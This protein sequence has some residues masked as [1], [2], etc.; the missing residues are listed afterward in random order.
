MREDTRERERE[1]EPAG[2]QPETS[3][4]KENSKIRRRKSGK[5]ENGGT[6]GRVYY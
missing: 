1:R 3:D 4:E 6:S 5:K 2:H